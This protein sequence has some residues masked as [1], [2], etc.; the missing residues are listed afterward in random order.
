MKKLLL[1]IV[2]L[3]MGM[4]MAVAQ[5]KTVVITGEDAL[6][7]AAAGEQT[8]TKDGVTISTTQGL[9]NDTQYRAF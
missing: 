5:V 9:G 4:G 6:W 2:A 3:F 8:G 7:S 1:S